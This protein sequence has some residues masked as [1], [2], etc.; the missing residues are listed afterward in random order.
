MKYA[1][2]LK[3]PFVAPNSGA[4]VFHQP[5]SR[6]VFNVRARYQDEVNVALKHFSSLGQR[7]V[8]LI[9]VDDAFGRDGA[10]GYK[11]GVRVTGISS[12]YEGS[13]AADKPDFAKHVNALLA[14]TPD[15][16]ICIGSSK[17]VAEL[18]G[19]ARQ[20]DV[21][22]AF[23]TLSNNSS[24]GFPR[25]LGR[26]ARGVIVSQVTP[27]PGNGSTQLSQELRKLLADRPN[28][29]VSYAA[30]EAYASAKVLVEGLR[31]AG[32]RLTREGFV[33]ALEAMRHVDIGGFD[34]DY[35]STR[36]SGSSFVELS[37][38]TRD[39]RYIR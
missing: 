32:P 21:L 4:N 30:M 34:I 33:Q 7:R 35:S 23:M 28:A 19:L 24:A 13:F 15:A 12:V 38:L 14:A 37:I 39:G 11:E 36:R 17:R 9:H 8:A 10:E 26:N 25:E 22:S 6:W 20:A 27:P 1:T 16:V 31:R 18:I 29:E 5:P 3:I 2:P